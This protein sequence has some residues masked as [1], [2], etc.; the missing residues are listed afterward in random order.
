M[1]K[2]YLYRCTAQGF[3]FR[4]EGVVSEK[5]EMKEMAQEENFSAKEKNLFAKEKNNRLGHP[6][7]ERYTRSAMVAC[8]TVMRSAGAMR[9]WRPRCPAEQKMTGCWR[10]VVWM[11]VGK[12]FFIPTGLQPPRM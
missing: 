11:N 5:K 6:Y 7:T 9:N 12:C 4:K 3:H 1:R 10:L 8:A 2:L